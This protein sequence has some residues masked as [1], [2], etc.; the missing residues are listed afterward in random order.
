VKLRKCAHE[1]Y[2]M[3]SEAFGTDAMEKSSVFER[4]KRLKDGWLNVGY[5]EVSSQKKTQKIR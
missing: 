1:A 4:H 3:L 2:A 5:I